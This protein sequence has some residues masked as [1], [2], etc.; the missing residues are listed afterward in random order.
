MDLLSLNNFRPGLCCLE[1]KKQKCLYVDHKVWL[2]ITYVMLVRFVHGF[3]SWVAPT[4]ALLQ[5]ELINHKTPSFFGRSKISM[6][7][8]R[9]HCGGLCRRG[10]PLFRGAEI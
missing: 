8:I 3:F 2:I 10:R 1:I 7:K 5:L 6:S 4:K 9:L